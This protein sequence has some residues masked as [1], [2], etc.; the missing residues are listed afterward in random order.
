MSD[1]PILFLVIG[2]AADADPD[3]P[4]VE[5]RLGLTKE[6]DPQVIA[7]FEKNLHLIY[8]EM[9]GDTPGRV[10][11]ALLPWVTDQDDPDDGVG[12]P[13]IDIEELYD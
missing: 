9:L 5:V 4:C 10:G 12:H 11:V 3:G 13:V 7:D 2:R 8:E 6:P 1:D